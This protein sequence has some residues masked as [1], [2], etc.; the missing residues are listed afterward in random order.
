MSLT[1]LTQ[2]ICIMFQNADRPMVLHQNG[3]IIWANAGACDLF[4]YS[5]QEFMSMDVMLL[6]SPQERIRLKSMLERSLAHHEVSNHY[7]SWALKKDGTP[8]ELH[9]IA[10]PV[11]LDNEN[12]IQILLAFYEEMSPLWDFSVTASESIHYWSQQYL[13]AIADQRSQTMQEKYLAEV[14]LLRGDV[15]GLCAFKRRMT[16]TFYAVGGAAGGS[17][18][19]AVTS[20]FVGLWWP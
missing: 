20:K 10:C 7:Q 8:F 17:I 5:L 19:V 11:P 13:E 4:G 9:T 14:K 6:A 2:L 1:P 15:D 3:N 18:V 12:N 16:K